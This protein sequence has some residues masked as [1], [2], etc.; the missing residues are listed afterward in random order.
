MIYKLCQLHCADRHHIQD[1]FLLS[2]CLTLTHSY[3]LQR[4]I[5]AACTAATWW[6]QTGCRVQ[7]VSSVFGHRMFCRIVR[8]SEDCKWTRDLSATDVMDLKSPTNCL[9]FHTMPLSQLDG[10]ACK[11]WPS[12]RNADRC[13][14][15]LEGL[16]CKS[17]TYRAHHIS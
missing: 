5:T 7:I 15:R 2:C 17:V 8:D 16:L 12:A 6:C 4:Q 10:V 3:F 9:N 14:I 13:A 1:T 11:F